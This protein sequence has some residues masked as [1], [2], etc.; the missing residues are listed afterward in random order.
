M[1]NF[2]KE[3]LEKGYIIHNNKQISVEINEQVFLYEVEDTAQ[4]VIDNKL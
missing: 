4:F 1:E 3:L 2:T